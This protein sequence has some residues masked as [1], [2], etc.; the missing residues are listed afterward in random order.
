VSRRAYRA[1]KVT[2]GSEVGLEPWTDSSRTCSLVDE[3]GA[4]ALRHR[5]LGDGE[6]V[7]GCLTRVRI[8]SEHPA[9]CVAPRRP[10]RARVT[11]SSVGSEHGSCLTT[12]RVGE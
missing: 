6:L 5:S 2:R 8:L 10:P 9:P 4:L 1:L 3:V 7:Q 12:G 11:C